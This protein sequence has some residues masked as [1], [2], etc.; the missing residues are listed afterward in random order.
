MHDAGG[1]GWS[2]PVFNFNQQAAG[3]SCPDIVCKFLSDLDLGLLVNIEFFLSL[4]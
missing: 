1:G 3:S 2:L 4:L